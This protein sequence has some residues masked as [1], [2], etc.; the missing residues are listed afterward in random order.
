VL[1]TVSV[2]LLVVT[3]ELFTSSEKVTEIVVVIG[4]SVSP[5]EGLVEEIVGAVVS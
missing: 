1:S 2:K 4:T 3:V 5:F